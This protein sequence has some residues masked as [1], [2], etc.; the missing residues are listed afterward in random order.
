MRGIFSS[1]STF[2]LT[3]TTKP[4]LNYFA[5]CGRG[6]LARLVAAAGEVEIE[7][8]AW[9]PAFGEDGGWRPGYKAIG[10]S[11]GFPGTMPVLEQGD[12]A[13]F[14]SH[15]VENYLASIAPKFKDLTP[16][17]RAKDLMFALIKGDINVP[18]ENVLFKKIT[19]EELKPTMEKYYSIIESQLP[20]EGYVNGLDF[21]TVA[22]LA[23]V[24]IA[25][26]CM[27]FQAA[28]QMAGCAF[29]PVKYPKMERVAAAAMAY[30][31]VAK[32]LETSEHKTLKAD[33]FNI[34]PAEYHA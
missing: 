20:D 16:Q 28:S 29:D 23:V 10:E 11:R 3:M 5:I 12:F 9:A 27:P 30:P 17:Q 6:E 8:K 7:D 21:P 24:V 15:A 4:T 19:P 32:F 26:G 2:A 34:M 25:K 31:P 18:T 13:I 33:P 14:Q 22:D 1:L